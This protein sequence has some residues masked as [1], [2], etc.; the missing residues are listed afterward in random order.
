MYNTMS[1]MVL[2]A[3]SS[4]MRYHVSMVALHYVGYADRVA[5]HPVVLGPIECSYCNH[6]VSARLDEM[7]QVELLL[8]RRVLLIVDVKSHF[9][10]SV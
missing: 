9:E 4:A 1:A 6:T 2:P 3:A 8:V 5:R 10:Q 7:A